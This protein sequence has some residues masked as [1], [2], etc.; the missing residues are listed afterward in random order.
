MTATTTG[1][2]S[3]PQA[4][5]YLALRVPAGTWVWHKDDE[6]RR[7]WVAQPCA[8]TLCVSATLLG[9]PGTHYELRT[10]DDDMAP[11]VH[12]RHTSVVPHLHPDE[13]FRTYPPVLPAPRTAAHLRRLLR[14]HFPGVR[15]SVRARRGWRLTVSW[16]GGPSDTEV[17]TVAAPL[18][19]DYATPGRRRARPVTVTR[20]GRATHGTP[21][22]NAV[23]LAHR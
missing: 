5:G 16:R 12:V 23:T 19:A 21:L 18:L 17:A 8:C 10:G 6:M 9:A 15:F 22:V 13:L 11:M 2:A 20:F 7:I 1:T 14:A 4:A 3:G